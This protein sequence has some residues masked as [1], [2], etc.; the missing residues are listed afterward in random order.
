[1]SLAP[2]PKSFNITCSSDLLA[3]LAWEIGQARLVPVTDTVTTG[4]H[5]WNCAI[6]AWHVL[7]WLFDERKPVTV[8]GKTFSRLEPFQAHIRGRSAA[9]SQCY[10]FCNGGKHG[11]A[12]GKHDPNIRTDFSV[13]ASTVTSR[14]LA[15]RHLHKVEHYGARERPVAMFEQALADLE[16]I[17]AEL[18]SSLEG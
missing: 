10:Q 2:T 15:Y 17:K 14:V 13:T 7:D 5:F 8:D 6:T 11:P 3:K 12:F 1:M 16:Q 9:L 4:Y 18:K